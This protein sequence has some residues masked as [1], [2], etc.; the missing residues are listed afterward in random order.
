[1]RTTRAHTFMTQRAAP[2]VR[3]QVTSTRDV[4]SVIRRL[5]GQ[6]RADVGG[7]VTAASMPV[8]HVAD[9]SRQ[10]GVVGLFPVRTLRLE[11]DQSVADIKAPDAWALQDRQ[12][13]PVKGNHVL[14]GIV[15]GGVDYHSADFKNPDGSSR[16]RFIWD[17]T[18]S[19]HAPKGFHYGY[20]CNAASINTTRC[21]ERDN[22]DGHGT[23]VL[24]IA[25]GNG[26]TTDPVREMGV[27]PQADIMIVKSDL[28]S[29][30]VIAAWKYLI[31]RAHQLHEPIVINNSF[32]DQNGP[33]DGG[34]PEALAID[35]LSGPGQIFVKSAGNAGHQG[36]HAIG[37][38]TRG[39]TSSLELV[40][41]G[42][43]DGFDLDIFYRAGNALSFSLRNLDTH[44]TFGPVKQN[45]KIV[46]KNAADGDTQ[47]SIESGPY[48][49][50]YRQAYVS[51]RSASHRHIHGR[52]SLIVRGQ[53]TASTA[54]YDAWID[55]QGDAEFKHAAE[56]TT[57]SIPG[58][59]HRVITVGNYATSTA[60]TDENNA[61]HRVCD[62][63][64]CVNG[65]LRVGDIAASSS[66][67]PTTDGRQKPDIAAPGTMI[68]STLTHD[69]PVC[70][71]GATDNCIDPVQISADGQHLTYTGTSM[72]APHVA[73][74]IALLLQIN[75]RLTPAAIDT[76]LRTSARRDSFTGQSVW[77]PTFG[78]GKL[79]ALAAVRRAMS[80]GS[81]AH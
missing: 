54:R 80:D 81:T 9:L 62:N 51:L 63:F 36:T 21:P 30:N 8:G 23:H 67:G 45:G 55:G 15:D 7:T 19:G 32:G 20:E 48:S 58:D 61:Q 34:E 70:S 17:Q 2:M 47:V 11:G 26:R 46:G 79:D 28:S 13:Q 6:I 78:A 5:G 4:S 42:Y 56:A 52:F 31:D 40:P 49:A 22:Q 33:H 68:T 37:T 65:V 53:H 73:G 44:E 3:L 38:V 25:A 27:A 74:T 76:I 77:T 16:I 10:A 57:M 66:E 72:A 50:T 64:V 69:A 60:W 35:R 75:P 41:S 1:M 71:D 43:S 29:D 12:G 59:A 24:G 39:G 18:V 14:V